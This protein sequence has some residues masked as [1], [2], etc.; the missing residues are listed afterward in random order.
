MTF[1][2][3][4]TWNGQ[5]HFSKEHAKPSSHRLSP[6]LGVRDSFFRLTSAEAELSLH[7][8]ISLYTAGTLSDQVEVA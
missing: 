2:V 3:V 4:T 7:A 1:F 6:E 8:L 5:K